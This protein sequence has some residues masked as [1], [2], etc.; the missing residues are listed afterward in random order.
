[1]V[2]NERIQAR[3]QRAYVE[4]MLGVVGRGLVSASQVDSEVNRELQAFPPGYQIQMMVMPE[5]PAFTVEVVANGQL[6]L[7]KQA[8]R[9]PD[10]GVRF[11]HLSHAVLVLSF[12]E[13]TARAFANDRLFVD[14]DVSHAIRLVRCLSRM[15]SLILPKVIAQRAVKRYPDIAWREKLTLAGRIYGRVATNFVKGE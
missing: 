3:A 8:V 4:L 15:E 9:R 11:K 2:Q 14:G 12:Q 6:R 5:G 13:G 10:L 1:M 7:I